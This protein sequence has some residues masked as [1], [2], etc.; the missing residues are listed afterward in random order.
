MPG[1]WMNSSPPWLLNSV[2]QNRCSP[3]TCVQAPDPKEDA[4]EICR[5]L[6]LP[7]L[8]FDICRGLLQS[9]CTTCEDMLKT[10][11]LSRIPLV[12]HPHA[13]HSTCPP[14]EKWAQGS[15]SCLKK[16]TLEPVDIQTLN[17]GR[18]GVVLITGSL[19]LGGINISYHEVVRTYD[20]IGGRIN[21]KSQSTQCKQHSAAFNTES[22][23]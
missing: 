5:L 20:G 10:D 2:T 4:L 17:T 15:L 11:V 21:I 8:L 12:A 19:E 14:H 18:K 3:R 1:V 13:P 9:A 16:Q 22:H 6:A 7:D 23:L